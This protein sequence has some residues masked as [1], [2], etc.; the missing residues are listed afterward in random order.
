[1]LK[2]RLTQ[3]A[4]NEASPPQIRGFLDITYDER[5]ETVEEHTFMLV[6]GAGD[7]TA[8]TEDDALAVLLDPGNSAAQTPIPLTLPG[9]TATT[10][11]F[12]VDISGRMD[13]DAHGTQ[14]VAVTVLGWDV[15]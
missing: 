14:A 2:P 5:P 12:V 6:L 3:V 11:G 7:F 10:Y 8:E 9:E 13:L 1:M 15:A 4:D